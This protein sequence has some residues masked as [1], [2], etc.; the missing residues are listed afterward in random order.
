[1]E[2]FL[3]VASPEIIE[4]INFHTDLSKQ[5]KMARSEGQ[6]EFVPPTYLRDNWQILS[7]IRPSSDT[8]ET[9]DDI[10]ADTNYDFSSHRNKYT[11]NQ[12]KLIEN[13]FINFQ[14]ELV[15]E[16]DENENDIPIVFRE[17]LNRMQRFAFDLVKYKQE[18]KEQLL[19]IINGSAGTGKSFSI[20]SLSHMLKKL[21]K[22][23]APNAKA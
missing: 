7:E 12:L 6:E 21:V 11:T 3:N 14:K 5:L 9:S 15:G 13:N 16:E 19:M 20:F 17:Q 10:I 4:I 22:R 18:K 1:M 2:Q 23:S 8:C